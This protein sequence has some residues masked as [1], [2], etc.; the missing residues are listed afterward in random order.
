MTATIDT[1]IS[2]KTTNKLSPPSLW[3]VIVINDDLT[4]V[5]FV[6]SMLVSIFRYNDIDARSLTVEIHNT[7]SAIAGIYTHEIAEQRGLDATQ[8]ARSNGH[9][10]QLTLDKE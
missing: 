10:L 2:K 9:P 7:G 4:P 1:I 5:D 3:K 6:V 8:L